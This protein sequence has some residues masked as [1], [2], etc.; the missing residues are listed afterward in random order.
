MKGK[1]Y[2]VG[3]G[4]GDPELLTVKAL[5]LLRTAD[6]V[7]HDDLVAP[8]ILKLIPSTAEVQNVGKRCGQKTMRQEEI[9]FLMVTL[10]A[11]GRQVVRLK[12]GDPLIFGR[13]GEEIEALRRAEYRVRNCS[14]RD[15]GSGSRGSGGHSAD[16]SASFLHACADRRSSCVRK[17]RFGLERACRSRIDFRRL[18][19][20]SGLCRDG[21]RL[22]AAG[23]AE[24]TPCAV[25][26]RATTAEQRLHRT[27]VSDLHRTPK[28]PAPTLLVVGEVVRFVDRDAIQTRTGVPEL[29]Q[30]FAFVLEQNAI[31]LES[32]AARGAFGMK[33]EM[34]QLQAAA[35]TWSA[36][37]VLELGFDT[38]EDKVAISTAFG[39][40]GMVLI[41]I[42]SK[43]RR[44]FRLFTLDTEFLFPETY[45]LMDQLEQRYGIA[46]ERVYPLALA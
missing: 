17:F 43:V 11:S 25:I 15:L 5:R 45:N 42:A 9:N 31:S 46:I 35:E 29:E 39:D 30:E 20:R 21:S 22:A 12:S 41:D 36:E 14:W 3:A 38:F 40:G 34:K 4:P 37:R 7:L 26:S 24:E 10:A 8:E 27:T 33:E 19:A 13:A 6:V 28:L 2:L 44:K 18:H 16:A 23:F 1:V 32:L